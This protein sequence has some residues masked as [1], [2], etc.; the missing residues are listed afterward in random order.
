MLASE[1]LEA[2]EKVDIFG[3]PYV[4]IGHSVGCWVAMEV[5]FLA[6]KRSRPMPLRCFF[7]AMPA[8]SIPEHKRPWK[9]QSQMSE[10]EFKNECALWSISPQV[11]TPDVWQAYSSLL[12]SDFRLFDEY[13]LDD[14]SFP[15][16]CP[17]DAF[18]GELDQRIT[19]QL[20]EEWSSW[21]NAEFLIQEIPK[22]NHLWPLNNPA[23]KE[24]WLQAIVQRLKSAAGSSLDGH[25]RQ[26]P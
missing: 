8:P 2:L 19:K 16:E 14:A 22:A 23:A 6:R 25:P 1:C 17:I 7:S 26:G 21:T 12:R 9:Q 11:F 13:D 4:F 18:Y 15:L 10:E 5:L 24:I 20:V 3:S